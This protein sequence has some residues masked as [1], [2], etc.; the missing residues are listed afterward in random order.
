MPDPT[1]LHLRDKVVVQFGGTGLLGRA[2]VSVLGTSECAVKRGVEVDEVD[3]RGIVGRAAGSL[4]AKYGRL[5]SPS[6]TPS[7]AR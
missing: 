4:V 7:A 3:I 6:S 2:L 1:A 5:T